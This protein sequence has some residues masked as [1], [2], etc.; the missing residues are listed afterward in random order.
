MA[1]ISSKLIS[2]LFRKPSQEE[3]KKKPMW[4]N[5][6]IMY[7][8]LVLPFVILMVGYSWA[9]WRLTFDSSDLVVSNGITVHLHQWPQKVSLWH[10]PPSCLPTD[11]LVATQHQDALTDHLHLLGWLGKGSAQQ[12]N[13]KKQIERRLMN[14]WETFLVRYAES[15]IHIIDQTQSN[16]GNY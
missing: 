1:C 12:T 13:S 16:I 11:L 4:Q 14:T 3:L 15:W 2:R 10:H 9:W 7:S 8:M 5:A 6:I